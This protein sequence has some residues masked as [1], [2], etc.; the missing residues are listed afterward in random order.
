MLIFKLIEQI[1]RNLETTRL[2]ISLKVATHPFRHDIDD[3]GK[4]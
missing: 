2:H 1:A 3:N 4:W